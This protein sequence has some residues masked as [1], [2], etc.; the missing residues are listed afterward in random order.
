MTASAEPD[1]KP[2]SI[3][4]SLSQAQRQ[5]QKSSASLVTIPSKRERRNAAAKDGNGG[6]ATAIN[7]NSKLL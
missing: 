5:A 7:I 2:T 3:I 4:A 1:R 6:P